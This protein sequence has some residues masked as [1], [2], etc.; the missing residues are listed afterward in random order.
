MADNA[1]IPQ[2]IN[3]PVNRLGALLDWMSQRQRWVITAAIAFQVVFLIAMM[4][5][6]LMMVATGETILLRVQPVDPRDLFRGDYVILS[7]EISRPGWSTGQQPNFGT[8]SRFENMQG[9]TVYVLLQ[10][11]VDGKHWQ[12]SDVQFEPPTTGKFIRGTVQQNGTIRFGI[13]QFFVQEGK[14]REYEEAVRQ[15]KLSAE[16]ILGTDGSSQL[17]RLIID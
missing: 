6:P 17:K 13:E 4:I 12:S 1:A 8:R 10:S 7:Y 3:W 14:G 11:D 16:V 9:K 15:H 5:R 2:I